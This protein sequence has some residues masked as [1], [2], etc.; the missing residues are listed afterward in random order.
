MIDIEF[1]V[2]SNKTINAS[3]FELTLKASDK[4]P[5][6]HCGQFV[7]LAINSDAFLLR[8]P[9]CVYKFDDTSITLLIAVLGQGT[10]M[11][12]KVKK[13]EKLLATLP[14]GNGFTLSEHHKKV[15]LIG[16]GVG[17]APL[18][19]VP[20]C[21]PNKEY[22]T[23]IGFKTKSEVLMEREFSKVSTKT[24]ITTEDGSY[25]IKGYSTDA[26][27]REL[28]NIAPDVVLTC[29]P[30]AMMKAVAKVCVSANIPGFMSSESRMGCGVGACL[31]CACKVREG[32]EIVNKRACVEGPVFSL[33]EILL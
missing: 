21:Y 25:G 13:G 17:G 5:K 19:S 29:G 30:T 22:Y 8:R 2:K 26:L 9:F 1:S 10:H 15:V 12:S 24:F 3:L 16:G 31:V 27:S 33:E 14:L 7:H 23:F 18:L 28:A 6:I 20:K 4:L 32:E 11:L